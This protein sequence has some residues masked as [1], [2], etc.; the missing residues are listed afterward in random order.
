MRNTS[1]TYILTIC[2]ILEV[3]CVKKKPR[4]HFLVDFSNAFDS[5]QRGKM[6]KI[7]LVYSRPKDTVTA[8]MM[9]YKNTKVKTALTECGHWNCYLGSASGY[10]SSISVYNMSR[11]RTS[12]VDRSNE[13]K[14]LYTKKARNRR[15]PIQAITSR[16]TSR[17]WQINLAEPN[18]SCIVQSRQQ[19]TLTSMEIKKKRSIC[20]L[21]KKNIFPH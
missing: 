20:I 17:F 11:Q 15:C 18:P 8:I 7:L 14:W 9:L 13:R 6:E 19:M 2:W 4:W 3:V 21:I 12:N 16:M 10:I 1:T 5:I